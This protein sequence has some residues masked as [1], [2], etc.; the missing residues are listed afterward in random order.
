MYNEGPLWDRPMGRSNRCPIPATVFAGKLLP[1]NTTTWAQVVSA[2]VLCQSDVGDGRQWYAFCALP[3]GS[4]KAGDSWDEGSTSADQGRSVVDYIK[5][6]HEGWSVFCVDGAFTRPRRLDAVDGAS[7][8]CRVA[9][10][11]STR[12]RSAQDRR[13]LP[14]FGSDPC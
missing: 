14:D 2:M 13:D 8:R 5:G 4:A 3:A 7:R 10:A 1:L 9:S 12:V 6:L 11:P